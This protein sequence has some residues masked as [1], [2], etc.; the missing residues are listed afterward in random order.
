[1]SV[2]FTLL[3]IRTL[4]AYTPGHGLDREGDAAR[5][6]WPAN[7]D[8][9]ERSE[10]SPERRALQAGANARVQVLKGQRHA[11]FVEHAP[12]VDAPGLA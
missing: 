1:M 6:R 10:V 9:P 2:S 3:K 4:G 12:V 11:Q 8:D 7:A 5:L